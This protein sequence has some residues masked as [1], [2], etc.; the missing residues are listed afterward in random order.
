MANSNK[1]SNKSKTTTS[2]IDDYVDQSNSTQKALDDMEVVADNIDIANTSVSDVA[3]VKL[4]S[5]TESDTD[6]D[7]QSQSFNKFD[8]KNLNKGLDTK[9]AQKFDKISDDTSSND[10]SDD[11]KDSKIDDIK[12]T[13]QDVKETA[14]QVAQDVKETAWDKIDELT[15]SIGSVV[16]FDDKD[17][18]TN[19]DKDDDTNTPTAQQVAK[20][21]KDAAQDVKETAQQVT[22]DVKETAWD[23]IDELTKSIGS[24]VGF[25]DKDDDTNTPTAQQVAKETAQNKIDELAKQLGAVVNTDEPDDL[26]VSDGDGLNDDKEDKNDKDDKKDGQKKVDNQVDAKQN[27][28]TTNPSDYYDVGGISGLLTKAGAY[29]GRNYQDKNYQGVDLHDSTTTKHPFYIQSSTL[30]G[31]FVKSIFGKK[32]TVAH[33]LADKFISDDKLNTISQSVYEKI[34]ELARAWALRTLPVDPKTLSSTQKDELAQSLAN[35]NR[36]L[37]TAGGVTGFFGLTGV[38]MDTAWLLLVALRTVYQLSAVYGVPLTKKEGIKMAYSVLS[39]ADLD[40]MQEKQIIL[41]ALALAKKTLVYAGE[42]GLKEELIK[43][44]SSN[45]NIDDFDGLLKF[46][47]LDKLVEKYG[48]DINGLNTH[49]SH[50]LVAVSAVGVAAHYN[51]RLI[52]EIIG[53]AMATFKADEML[54]VEYQG[55]ESGE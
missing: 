12:E 49:W 42:N 7:E 3:V 51:H 22:Q 54:S 36:A 37:A 32:V 16:G 18:D 40:K 20:D 4:P 8:D 35:Q 26:D 9:V 43:L 29:L 30:G 28:S 52:D 27:H 45:I 47:H 25:D 38:V 15:K 48:I 46:T 39:G 50:R 11:S 21:I 24:A 5:D 34:A 17:D 6:N 33:H 44:S 13:A 23:K 19:D 41:T 14:Q 53:T 1:T 10:D 31:S 55:N 2:V